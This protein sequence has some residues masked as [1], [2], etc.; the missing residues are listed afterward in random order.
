MRQNVARFGARSAS[1]GTR[2]GVA[3]WG[4]SRCTRPASVRSER[5]FFYF[6]P[7]RGTVLEGLSAPRRSGR[8]AVMWRMLHSGCVSCRPVAS[9]SGVPH[10]TLGVWPSAVLG[11]PPAPPVGLWSAHKRSVPSRVSLVCRHKPAGMA[12]RTRGRSSPARAGL[13][14]RRYRAGRARARAGGTVA[15][16]RA[17]AAPGSLCRTAP[18]LGTRAARLFWIQPTLPHRWGCPHPG[19][20]GGLRSCGGCSTPVV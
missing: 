16:A 1:A 12:G 5:S 2:I 18:R 14:C 11:G 6:P 7:R 19:A 10:P 3:R 9:R 8:L 4:C 15:A 20:P 17:V 13:P